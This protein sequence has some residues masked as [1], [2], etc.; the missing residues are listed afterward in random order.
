MFVLQRFLKSQCHFPRVYLKY[1][2][3]VPLWTWFVTGCTPLPI[4][5][6]PPRNRESEP[7]HPF[8]R[9]VVRHRSYNAITKLLL[10]DVFTKRTMTGRA[11]STSHSPPQQVSHFK[12]QQNF[13]DAS[14]IFDPRSTLLG[15]ITTKG[16]WSSEWEAVYR[17]R[18][19]NRS[20]RW[21]VVVGE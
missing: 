5:T 10:F 4:H 11:V 8:S 13:F 20:R 17:K 19:S 7:P 14:Y 1:T 12:S 21:V 2:W 9:R 18:D 3:S 6:L 15:P 16:V